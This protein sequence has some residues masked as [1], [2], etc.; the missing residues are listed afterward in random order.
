MGW[1]RRWLTLCRRQPTPADQRLPEEVSS[2]TLILPP[3][4]LQ[5]MIHLP[6]RDIRLTLLKFRDGRGE[7]TNSVSHKLLNAS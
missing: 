3:S 6:G 1:Q 2:V 7:R 5:S 4:E